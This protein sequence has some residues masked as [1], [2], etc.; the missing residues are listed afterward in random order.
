MDSVHRPKVSVCIPTFRRNERLR[1][2][3]DDL[4]RQDHL[5]D[6]VV[7]V[8]NDAAGG[9]RPVI[10]ALRADRPPFVLDYEVQP[11][12]NISITRNRT[13]AL[14]TGEWLAFIDDDE[15]APVPWLGGMLL[16]AQKYQADAILSPVV[17]E[18]PP[19]APKWL[20][21]GKLYEFA[22]QPEGAPVP[23]NCMRFGNVLLRGD[24]VR[25]E[26]EPFDAR[27]GLTAGE[28]IDLLARLARKGSKIIWTETAPVIEPIE[29]K[30][31]SL[32]WL[33]RRALGGGQGFAR[34]AVVGGFGSLGPFGR[35]G[36][37]AGALMKMLVSAIVAILVLPFGRHHGALWLIKATANAGK[38]SV[39]WG[40][41][42][43]IY[44]RPG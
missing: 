42:H 40:G 2:L 5:P 21:R 24:L 7:V 43:E 15:R 28:D 34:Y 30:R 13:V 22:H 32:A 41:R 6:Q 3:L 8:D 4:V 10:E 18:L 27:F 12:P 17:P 16:A 38:L 35:S 1:V 29:P 31:L 9:A 39:L 23:T 11:V 25:G 14:A 20:R 19:E 37:Y 33:L 44:G 36:L 26:A